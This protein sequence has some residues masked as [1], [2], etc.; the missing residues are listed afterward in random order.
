MSYGGPVGFWQNT[1]FPIEAGETLS[2]SGQ[3]QSPS[4]NYDYTSSYLNLP[5]NFD[6]FLSFDDYFEPELFDSLGN[7]Y[8]PSDSEWDAMDF[9]LSKT[10]TAV[11]SVSLVYTYTPVPEPATAILMVIGLAGLT[12]FTRKKLS[13]SST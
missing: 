11:G 4:Y 6:I 10:M 7:Y 13:I 12:S 9:N 2:L 3:I 1:P 8:S 5:D